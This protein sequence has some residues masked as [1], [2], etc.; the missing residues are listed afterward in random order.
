[1]AQLAPQPPPRPQK[2]ESSFR[3]V[4]GKIRGPKGPALVPFLPATLQESP[5]TMEEG[6]IQGLGFFPR[7]LPRHRERCDCH[8]HS[9]TEGQDEPTDSG[10][11]QTEES[12]SKVSYPEVPTST[13]ALIP[14]CPH[15]FLIFPQEQAQWKSAMGRDPKELAHTAVDLATSQACPCPL[16][17]AIRVAGPISEPYCLQAQGDSP[18]SHRSLGQFLTRPVSLLGYPEG[19]GEN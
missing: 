12:S 13:L 4:L 1:M 11:R 16:R 9:Q 15:T 2:T 14:L 8:L 18:S 3:L 17:M 6:S 7:A 5:R 19:L 10:C